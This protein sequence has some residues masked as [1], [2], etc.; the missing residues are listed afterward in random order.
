MF[1]FGFV[2]HCG[3]GDLVSSWFCT[4]GVRGREEVGNRHGHEQWLV[5]YEGRTDEWFLL[6]MERGWMP[7]GLG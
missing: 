6:D 1:V 4:K 5:Y 2:S 7:L 3:L